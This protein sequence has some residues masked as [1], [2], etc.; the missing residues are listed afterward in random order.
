M[1]NLNFYVESSHFIKIPLKISFLHIKE[2]TWWTRRLRQQKRRSLLV[3]W[4][5]SARCGWWWSWFSCRRRWHHFSVNSSAFNCTECSLAAFLTTDLR[6]R[7]F[8]MRS[9]CFNALE[10]APRLTVKWIKR[11][12]LPF[13]V[14]ILLTIFKIFLRFFWVWAKFGTIFSKTIYSVLKNLILL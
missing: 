2:L 9:G 13:S 7:E 1:I 11:K 4:R 5:R 14:V 8:L 12:Y 10:A 6:S 3:G